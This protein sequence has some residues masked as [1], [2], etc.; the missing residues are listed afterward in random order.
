MASASRYM[1]GCQDHEALTACR[2][3]TGSFGI[4]TLVKRVAQRRILIDITTITVVRPSN[5][6][7][8]R[9]TLVL[10][11]SGAKL[12]IVQPFIVSRDTLAKA[13]SF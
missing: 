8:L 5:A 7:H 6:A 4:A 1:T 2:V 9:D 3:F 11:V 13:Q 12:H 10:A